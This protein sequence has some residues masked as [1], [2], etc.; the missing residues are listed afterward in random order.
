MA[1]EILSRT[2]TSVT[3]KF[4]I[5]GSA[6]MNMW[7]MKSGDS[8]WSSVAVWS[9]G[10]GPIGS[11]ITYTFGWYSFSEQYLLP[12][13]TYNMRLNAG[14]GVMQ[15]FSVKTLPDVYTKSISGAV[16]VEESGPFPPRPP[17]D[18]KSRLMGEWGGS[19]WGDGAWG[20]LST[21]VKQDVAMIVGQ[22]RI[23]HQNTNAITGVVRIWKSADKSISGSVNVKK[24]LSK[25][26]TGAVDISAPSYDEITGCVT[27]HKHSEEVGHS[28]IVGRVRIA[29]F[30]SK[31]IVGSTRIAKLN[32]KTISGA[33]R[34]MEG[35]TTTISGLVRIVRYGSDTIS[36]R[37]RIR[38]AV[39]E[40]LPE[41]W[42]YAGLAEPEGWENKDKTS[43]GWEG[44]EK[45]EDEWAESEKEAT[46]WNKTDAGAVEW[47]YPL[48][49][50]R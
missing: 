3:L 34:I 39:P 42:E 18:A 45:P 21:G 31:D 47:G 10:W 32:S 46:S 6:Q 30:Y 5:A 25:A 19:A 44:V 29:K 1:V 9:A 24:T 49:D 2:E 35:E 17:V 20:G 4:Q 8:S 14:D 15:Y 7:A 40:K 28:D 13:T 38:V 11:W 22:V 36:G 33:V 27:I 41:E 23:A 43:T 12:N 16:Y 48:E 26:I 50:T 37:V